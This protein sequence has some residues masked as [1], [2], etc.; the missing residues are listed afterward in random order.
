MEVEQLD[1]TGTGVVE[2]SEVNQEV[3]CLQIAMN[4]PPGLQASHNADERVDD[5]NALGI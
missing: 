3:R 5:R 1:R 4:D 2:R